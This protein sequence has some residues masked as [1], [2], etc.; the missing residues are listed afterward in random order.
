VPPILSIRKFASLIGTPAPRLREIAANV[1]AHYRAFPLVNKNKVRQ[2]TAPDHELKVV[3]RRIVDNVLG[4]LTLG[5]GVHGGVRGRSPKSNAENHLGR[6]CVVTLDVRDFF[7]SVSH[8]RVYRMFRHE[9]GFGKDVASLLTRLTT[10]NG[11]LPQGAPTSTAIANLLLASPVDVPLSIEG[12]RRGVVSS[13]FVDDMA[14]SGSNPR[15]MI[16]AAGKMLSRRG[17]SIYRQ[18]AKGQIKPK[19]E[20][21]VRSQPQEITGLNVNRRSGPSV[22]RKRRDDVRAAIHALRAMRDEELAPAT[23]SVRGRINHVRRFNPGAAKSLRTYLESTLAARR[24]AK[25][26]QRAQARDQFILGRRLRAG[27][28]RKPVGKPSEA[29]PYVAEMTLPVGQGGEAPNHV[30]RR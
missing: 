9:H 13:R 23:V 5:D 24:G 17:L 2:I 26:E 16:N 18:N 6:P 22:P 14:F 20:I 25:A 7:P 3:Q 10:F 15:P 27:Q 11:Q 4:K 19:L 30:S 29:D 1:K 12:K 21:R 8:S 28:S